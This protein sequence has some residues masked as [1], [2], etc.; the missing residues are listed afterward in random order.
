MIVRPVRTLYLDILSD[1]F[2]RRCRTSHIRLQ[3]LREPQPVG[4]NLT[5]GHEDTRD[6]PKSPIGT[7]GFMLFLLFFFDSAIS[8]KSQNVRAVFCSFFD[9]RRI[10]PL[11]PDW[12]HSPVSMLPD[13]EYGDDQPHDTGPAPAGRE[14]CKECGRLPYCRPPDRVG[15]FV[16]SSASLAAAIDY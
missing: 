3:A 4:P 16:E 11:N 1:G 14:P 5:N 10:P 8:R 2:I 13:P 15:R 6:R 9:A 7:D 12:R